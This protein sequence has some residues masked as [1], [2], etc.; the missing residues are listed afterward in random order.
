MQEKLNKSEMAKALCMVETTLKSYLNE[1]KKPSA[2]ELGVDGS[3]IFWQDR[4]VFVTL[5]IRGR[6]RGCIGHIFAIEPLWA[7]I[8]NNAIAA[9]VEDHRFL[10]LTIG[11]LASVTPSLSILT[12]PKSIKSIN[13][14]KVGRD[15]IIIESGNKRAVFL[16]QVAP[17]Q[18]WDRETTL[19]HLAQKAGLDSLGWKKSG[20]IFSTFLAQVIGE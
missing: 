18:G 5:K 10:P 14:F 19:G 11:E 4:A 1:D 7:S 6:L 8:R 17:E 20:V 15:G 9:A 2:A 12:P 16:P 3:S 13:D